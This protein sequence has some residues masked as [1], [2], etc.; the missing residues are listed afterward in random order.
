MLKRAERGEDSAYK[1]K[2]GHI[3]FGCNRKESRYKKI[4]G[5]G[6]HLRFCRGSFFM[7]GDNPPDIRTCIRLVPGQVKSPSCMTGIMGTETASGKGRDSPAG[8]NPSSCA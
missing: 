6:Y 7:Y 5:L 2:C 3:V 4:H 8:K 1:K